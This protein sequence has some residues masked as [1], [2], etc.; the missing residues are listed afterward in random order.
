MGIYTTDTRQTYVYRI[1]DIFE[2]DPS[3]VSVIEDVPNKK[4]ITLITC[5]DLQA[6]KRLVVRGELVGEGTYQ[7]Y[8]GYFA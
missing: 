4:L 2:V 7:E 8:A 3:D 5:T 1:T 6:T